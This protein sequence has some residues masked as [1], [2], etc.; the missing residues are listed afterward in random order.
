MSKVFG[1]IL[2]VVLGLFIFAAISAIIGLIL[3]LAWTYIICIVFA[4]A[5][6]IS[7]VQAWGVAVFIGIVGSIFKRS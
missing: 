6:S 3:Y 7:F 2:G 5:P 4:T 1:I